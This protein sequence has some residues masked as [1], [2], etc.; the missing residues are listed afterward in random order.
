LVSTAL[1]IDLCGNWMQLNS[2]KCS[3]SNQCCGN[4]NTD[5]IPSCG[6]P[7][8]LGGG[9]V[10]SQESYEFAGNNNYDATLMFATGNS[11]PLTYQSG[12]VLFAVDT[13][14][15]YTAMGDNTVLGNGWQKVMY[16][17]QRFIATITKNNPS[18]ANFFTPGTMVSGTLVGPCVNMNVLLNDPNRGCLCN[19]SWVA[20]GIANGATTSP[21]ATRVI[22]VSSCP[23]VNAT[24]SSCP[25]NFFFNRANRYGNARVSA[26]TTG[27]NATRLLE[28]T[29]PN[30]NQTE[31]YN[32]SVVY[33]NFT[34]DY[35]CPSTLN[36]SSPAGSSAGRADLELVPCFFAL[37]LAILH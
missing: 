32:D 9:S 21:T 2:G 3:T 10:V 5:T 20:G 15:I 25:E 24:T 35:S 36:G 37:L 27:A 19:G 30:L 7:P 18:Q 28:I 31:G 26:Y 6:C 22:N 29:Q 33:A 16:T 14:G 4:Q 11:C 8:T 17:P 13:Q 12:T 34:A 23:P 1:A